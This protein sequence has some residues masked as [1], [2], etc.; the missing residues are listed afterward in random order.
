M[1]SNKKGT[2]FT[3][4]ALALALLVLSF[5]L[6]SKIFSLSSSTGSDI[7]ADNTSAGEIQPQEGRIFS[8]D[9]LYP[10]NIADDS[11]T[12]YKKLFSTNDSSEIEWINAENAGYNDSTAIKGCNVSGDYTSVNNAI[13]LTLSEPLPAGRKY[14]IKVWFY[15]P[16]EENEKKSTLTAPGIVLNGDY[17]GSLYKLPGDAGAGIMPVDEWKAVDVETPGEYMPVDI[18]TIDFRFVVNEKEKHPDV[19]YIDNIEITQIG[20]EHEIKVPEPEVWNLSLPSLADTYK[21]YFLLGNIMEPNQ[22]ND[23]D[24]VNMFKTHYNALTAENAMKPNQISSAKGSYYYINADSLANWAENLDIAIHG[25]TLVWHSQSSPWLNA[26]LTREEAK[27]NMEEYINEVAGHYK[28]KFISWDVVNEA[29]KDGGSLA[30]DWRNVLRRDDSPW[31]LAYENGADTEAGESG[32]DYI[33]DAFVLTRLADPDTTLYYNDYNENSQTKRDAIAMMVEELNEKWESDDRNNEPGRLLIEGIGMQSHYF[34]GD[35]NVDTVEAAIK[36]FI[37]T[38]AI[39]SISE[40]DIPYGTYSNQ[41]PDA[42]LTKEQEIEQA[43]LY[44]KLFNIYKH[45]SENIERVTIWGKADS[46]SWRANGKPLLFNDSF[47][48]KEA[49]AA[50]INPETY[51]A[52]H[53]PDYVFYDIAS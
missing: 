44:A 25:H 24:T 2:F 28:G 50:V 36:R 27:V 45:Y 11:A 20:G 48:E 5:I 47:G 51:L 21:D 41:H 18:T 40:L 14:N 30:G 22:I 33:Y 23:A 46:Q 38:G 13:R 49:Y 4:I 8:N 12:E 39:I 29:F 53:A 19:W 3:V 15:V 34:V 9:S 16:A 1:S 32:A 17:A 43:I 42:T 10:Y 35:L 37:E 52:E 6:T 26:G 7:K 31:Y